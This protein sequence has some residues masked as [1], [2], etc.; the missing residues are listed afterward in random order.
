M[1]LS[2]VL[3]KNIYNNGWAKEAQVYPV[4]VGYGT[5]ILEMWGGGTG[6]SLIKGWASIPESYVAQV[7][8]LSLDRILGNALHGK[9]AL[10]LV[11]IE[12]AEL[13]MLQGAIET[14]SHNPR[15]IWIVEISTREHQPVGIM[16]NPNFTETFAMFF[17]RG[18]RAFTADER[19]TELTREI[20]EEVA[21]G[22]S[23]LTTHNFLFR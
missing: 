10:I 16:I 7:P 21:A 18:Y 9:R 15:P 4:A 17:T 23:D 20:V 3:L 19:Q 2:E 22:K 1:K 5:N 13:M 14:L 11:D 6:A 8:V 12:G